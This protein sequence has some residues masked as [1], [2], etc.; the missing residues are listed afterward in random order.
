VTSRI[1]LVEDDL[2]NRMTLAALLEDERFEV[3]EA[4]S[5]V[6]VHAMIAAGVR[7]DCVL[8]DLKLGDGQ[9]TDLVPSLRDAAPGVRI[10]LMSGALPERT[11]RGVDV[12]MAKPATFDRVLEALGRPSASSS[13]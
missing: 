3:D 6:A 9:G 10:V 1:L 5:V 4:D 7:W 2:A 13:R 11:P 12:V 8:L